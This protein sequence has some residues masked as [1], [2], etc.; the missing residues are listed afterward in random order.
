[1]TT[2]REQITHEWQRAALATH[3]HMTLVLTVPAAA[4]W[5]LASAKGDVSRALTL[6]PT[7]KFWAA[8]QQ[9]LNTITQ[10]EKK[11]V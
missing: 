9:I 6:S 8:A 11:T 7:G 5:L 1:M 10:E 3:E 4:G 2:T